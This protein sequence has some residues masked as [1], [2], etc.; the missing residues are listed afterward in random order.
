MLHCQGRVG[1]LN[2]MRSVEATDKSIE[3]LTLNLWPDTGRALGLGRGQTF[4]AAKNGQIP[5]V[6][7]GKRILVPKAAFQKLLSGGTNAPA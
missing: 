2:T 5:T 6:R 3:R 1:T 7:I 4:A